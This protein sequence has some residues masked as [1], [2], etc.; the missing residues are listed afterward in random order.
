MTSQSPLAFGSLSRVFSV[1]PFLLFF[2]ILFGLTSLSPCYCCCYTDAAVIVGRQFAAMEMKG[3]I[4]I[5][6]LCIFTFLSF[7]A[8][9][10]GAAKLALKIIDNIYAVGPS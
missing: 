10:L 7:P 1:V 2:K 8:C 9:L 4:E 3:K 5:L 6:F